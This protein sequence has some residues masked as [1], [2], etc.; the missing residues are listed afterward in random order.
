MDKMG[1]TQLSEWVELD[2]QNGMDWKGYWID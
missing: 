2:E 1:L